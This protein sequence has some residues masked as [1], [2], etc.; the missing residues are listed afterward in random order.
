MYVCLC[1]A[2]T[3]DEVASAIA[4]GAHSR[5][6]VSRACRAGGD[7]GS[8]H[9]MIEDMIDDHLEACHGC[10]ERSGPILPQPPA[11]VPETALVRTRAA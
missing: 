10:P 9:G 11:L 3:S 6:A 7:C 5:E 2:V 8:C 4:D 1:H